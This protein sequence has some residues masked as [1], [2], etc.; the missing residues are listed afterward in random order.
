[1]A[2]PVF[3]IMGNQ[4]NPVNN[5]IKQAQEFK[6]SFNG[7]PR[8]EVQKLLNSG[9]MSQQEFNRLSQIAQQVVQT[10]GGNF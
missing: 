7:N 2:N 3:S 4:S 5:I 8:E 1:M 10:M 6:K 9:K